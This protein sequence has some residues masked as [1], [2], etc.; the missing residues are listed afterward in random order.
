MLQETAPRRRHLIDIAGLLTLMAI[1]ALQFLLAYRRHPQHPHIGGDIGWWGWF[2]QE[3]YWSATLA[4]SRLDLDPAQHFYL[5]GYSML[6]APFVGL[7]SV[8]AFAFVNLTCLLASLLLFTAIAG[9]L[10]RQIPHAR[11]LGALV[12]TSV[13][14]FSPLVLDSWVVPWTTSGATPL[15]YAC[16]LAAIR[17]IETPR[18]A[19]F[20]FWAG[21]AAGAVAAFRPTDVIPLMAAC[22]SCMGLASF[23]RTPGSRAFFTALVC[24]SAG[25]GFALASVATVYVLVN[26]LHQNAYLAGSSMIGFEWRMI[27]MRWVTLF[28]DP[29][30]LFSDGQGMIE[31]FPWMAAGFAG[32]AALLLTPS[33]RRDQ[34]AHATV[35]LAMTLHIFLYLAYR[36]LHPDG[37]FRFRNYHY[38]K[39]IMPFV[40]L[41]GILFLHSVIF[42]YGR[43][44]VLVS[45]A[46]LF[47]GIALPW[48]AELIV[49]D[50]ATPSNVN[51]DGKTA[52]FPAG[53][54]AL[55]SA[56]LIPAVGEWGDIYFGPHRLAIGGREFGYYG[57]FRAFPRPGG[58]MLITLRELPR[59]QAQF[60]VRSTVTLDATTPVVHATQVLTLGFPCWLP[61]PLYMCPTIEPI[62]PPILK[63]GSVIAFGGPE[64]PYLG[65]GWSV[66]QPGG[67]W[68]EGPDAHVRVRLEHMDRDVILS[69]E[70]NGYNP[71]GSRPVDMSI[72]INGIKMGQSTFSTNE[73]DTFTLT[74]PASSFKGS[75][76]IDISLQ[77]HSPRAPRQ[78][79]K[80]SQ[81]FRKLGL[82][83]RAIRITPAS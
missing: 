30:P 64:A 19:V 75:G 60:T 13:T 38:F 69:I 1:A 11:L 29:R 9:R 42:A 20:A 27:P 67:R 8:H 21:L 71:A 2:D 35:I 57:D 22:A 36:D 48:R 37:L 3:R 66:T 24:G 51:A 52:A 79:D 54:A 76:W 83:V 28:L 26:G 78:F 41:Y 6:G 73:P 5:P 44:L 4:W 81:D 74:V 17:F 34:I 18:R 15:T 16:L 47:L 49:L 58:L 77:I 7:A 25:A 40:A 72:T 56:L 61:T 63:G 12:F 65:R 10:G 55:S 80:G 33:A 53:F 39:W 82:F 62:I 70:A 59:G 45:T 43:R 50:K 14:C 46:V 68:T 23:R 31:V 32:A